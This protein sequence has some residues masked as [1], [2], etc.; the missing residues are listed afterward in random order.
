MPHAIQPEEQLDNNSDDIID[1]VLLEYLVARGCL[2]TAGMLRST[3]TTTTFNGEKC[4]SLLKRGAY[5][6]QARSLIMQGC[7]SEVLE[8]L[9]SCNLREDLLWRLHH[10]V[11][12]E[13]VRQGNPMDAL[14]YT[15]QVLVERCPSTQDLNSLLV[16]I[17]LKDPWQYENG[18]L[19]SRDRLTD[20][21]NDVC[22]ALICKSDQTMLEHMSSMVI[23]TSSMKSNRA[24]LNGFGGIARKSKSVNAAD[25]SAAEESLMRMFPK[26]YAQMKSN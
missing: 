14:Q 21:A 7:I 25:S 24:G 23:Y 13:L 2:Q 17:A 15:K 19:M 20:L 1:S 22:T 11:V 3:H 4:N 5:A 8:M 10:Q 6:Q 12:I 9:S 16:I 18:K 26:Y